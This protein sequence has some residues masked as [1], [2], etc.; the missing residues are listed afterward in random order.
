M[1]K[2]KKESKD[3]ISLQEAS[4]LCSYS[5]EYLSLRARQG[6]LKAVKMGRNWVT[7]RDWLNKYVEQ[8]KK[9]EIKKEERVEE[10][11]ELIK[12]KAI[13]QKRIT[14][15]PP[16][17]QNF[18]KTVSAGINRV[19]TE[20][21]LEKFISQPIEQGLAFIGKFVFQAKAVLDNRANQLNSRYV[22][23]VDLHWK[24]IVQ[25]YREINIF[26]KFRQ[27]KFSL[28]ALLIV[29]LL[30]GSVFFFNSQARASLARWTNKSSA[31]LTA[32][33]EE[34]ADF[35]FEQTKQITGLPQ[36]TAK[37]TLELSCALFYQMPQLIE[38]TSQFIEETPGQL[39]LFLNQGAQWTLNKQQ[40][41]DQ[42]IGKEINQILILAKNLPQNTLQV[43]QKV[44]FAFKQA[45]QKNE[46]LKLA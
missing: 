40:R 12:E 14:E 9:E 22:R 28:S 32:S 8:T 13:P 37:K 19:K 34:T 23:F 27:P 31:L 24:Y 46:E 10:K 26:Q 1:N 29:C 15:R 18:L 43:I 33:G 11:R 41:A 42:K 3:Y 45:E 20:Q 4:G 36:K 30:I 2:D 25:A 7:T 21:K 35:V 17:P 5:Q 16:F 6:K 39:G 38:K 44:S